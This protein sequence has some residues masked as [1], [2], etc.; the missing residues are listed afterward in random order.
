MIHDEARRELALG[1]SREG[2]DQVFR[3]RV[4]DMPL[5]KVGKRHSLFIQLEGYPR[6]DCGMHDLT[7]SM[8]IL[9]SQVNILEKAVGV[10]CNHAKRRVHNLFCPP[11]SSPCNAKS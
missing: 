4:V 1:R 5:L 9:Y 10:S 2:V 11:V 3:L 8:D 6:Q 7:E